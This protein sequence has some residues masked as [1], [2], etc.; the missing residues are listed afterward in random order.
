MKSGQE[1]KVAFQQSAVQRKQVRDGAGVAAVNG[2][3]G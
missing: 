2:E 3:Q 1:R